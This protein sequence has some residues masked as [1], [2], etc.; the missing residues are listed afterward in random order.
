[1]LRTGFALLDRIISKDEV[2][3]FYSNDERLLRIFYHRVAALSAPIYV[4]LVSERGG[5]DPYLIGRFQDIFNNHN[6]VYLR[7][8]F[9][10]E[11]VPPT[12][13]SMRD[14]DLIIIDP[15][16]HNK[17]YDEIVSAIRKVKGRKFI[18]SFMDRERK[19]SIFGLHSAHS[20]IKLE[21]GIRGFKFVIKKSV[22]IKEIEIPASILT[23]YGK[24][25]EDEGLMRW[26]MSG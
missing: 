18:F 4:V 8:A 7:R 21:M 17:I 25:E 19:G 14:N 1:M 13:E 3:E 12:I 20:L 26:I 23:L 6:E 22:T 10:A 11:D 16:H 5:L 9:K 15:Y 2:V 24:I